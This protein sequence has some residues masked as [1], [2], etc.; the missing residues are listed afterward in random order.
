MS[1]YNPPPKRDKFA[2]LAAQQQQQPPKDLSNQS[3]SSTNNN[4]PTTFP[5]SVSEGNNIH[6]S[7]L[8]TSSV[9]MNQQDGQYQHHPS[10]TVP[11]TNISSS[12]KR[13]SKFASLAA[14]S[15]PKTATDVQQ[16]TTKR[17]KFA[18]LAA[19]NQAAVASDLSS[20]MPSLATA[21]A[22]TEM[23]VASSP[24][25]AIATPK[26]DKFAS[27]A[28]R[29]NGDATTINLAAAPKRDKFAALASSA[30]T[31]GSN[32]MMDIDTKMTS[33]QLQEDTERRKQEELVALCQ[34]RD[35]VWNDLDLAEARAMQL[36]KLSETTATSLADMA[37]CVNDDEVKNG[38]NHLQIIQSQYMQ[39]VSDIH[40][41]L[42][43]HAEFVQAYQA[44]TRMNRMYLQRVELRIAESKRSILE[45]FLRLQQIETDGPQNPEPQ[46]EVT[47]PTANNVDTK[48]AAAV[49]TTNVDHETNQTNIP[50]DILKR[51]REN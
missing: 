27:L 12:S 35:S 48:T 4:L 20:S 49:T 16:T 10:T 28:A 24:T 41:L 7:S 6:P 13:D 21:F 40:S 19:R 3:E 9:E 11:I 29:G 46:L 51:K 26:R 50:S 36:L 25:T 42:K 39:T 38:M 32:D 34:Q 5:L 8:T 15:Q 18:S 37:L 45:E 33:K 23:S 31:G 17:D 14:M 22:T 30:G 2:A 43:P 44:P 47:T 1:D